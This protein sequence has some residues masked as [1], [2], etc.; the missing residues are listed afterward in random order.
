LEQA[1]IGKRKN[2][3]HVCL[4]AALGLLRFGCMKGWGA[5]TRYLMRRE[6]RAQREPHF[7]TQ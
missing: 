7:F 5:T 6:V 2:I 1:S 3:K 4:R